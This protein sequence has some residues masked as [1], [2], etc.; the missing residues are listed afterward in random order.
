M[1]PIRH[2][3]DF[4]RRQ[5]K[6][7]DEWV[8]EE[9]EKARE[10][11]EFENLPLAGKPIRIYRTD[12]NPE[13]DLAFSRLKNAGVLPAWM[14]L[15]G[16]IRRLTGEMDDFLER[17]AAYLAEQR[18]ALRRN[19]AEEAATPPPAPRPWWQV[20]RALTD[21]LRFAPPE[22]PASPGPRSIAD[23]VGIREH[24]RE[25]YLAMAAAL[26]RTIVDYHNALPRELAHLQRLRMLPDRAA[27]R[28]D[29]RIPRSVVLEALPEPA[30]CG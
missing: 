28:F 12:V 25:Q 2:E 7:W 8:Q 14:E 1:S 16:K 13:Y 6:D 23:L 3:D 19:L 24:L 21:W 30:S 9:L 26:D 10:R 22:P 20:W 4:R 29:E 17:S 18:E 27:R 11:G 15:E 5:I